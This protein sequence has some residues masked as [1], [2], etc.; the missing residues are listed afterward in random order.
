MCIVGNEQT[1]FRVDSLGVQVGDFGQSLHRVKHHAVTDHA[2]LIIMHNAR[3][4]QVEHE[5]L[6][7]HFHG[8]ACIGA[9]LETHDIVCVQS[10]KINN[11]GLAFVTPLG[12]DYNTICHISFVFLS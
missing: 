6:V 12:T 1:A 2:N 11:L 5:L 9:A 10:Q 3:G 7:A 8:M 4:N